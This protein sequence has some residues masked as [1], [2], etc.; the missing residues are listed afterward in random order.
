MRVK[1]KTSLN[2]TLDFGVGP[3]AGAIYLPQL[4]EFPLALTPFALLFF[5]RP[6]EPGFTP[7]LLALRPFFY[8]LVCWLS[9]HNTLPL[10]RSLTNPW[11]S[12]AVHKPRVTAEVYVWS[13]NQRLSAYGA[14]FKLRY[15]SAA[16]D[17]SLGAFANRG[18]SSPRAWDPGLESRDLC[19]NPPSG[20]DQPVSL[21]GR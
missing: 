16:W 3:I 17:E 5:A 10:S 11:R 21:D 19:R 15:A 12:H 9:G 4:G 1:P 6:R 13:A 18:W 7:F 14:A 2:L 8:F 20:A